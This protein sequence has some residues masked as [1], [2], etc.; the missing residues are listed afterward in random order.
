MS[1]L[2]TKA[3]ITS[4]ILG[5][6][7]VLAVT[8]LIGSQFGSPVLPFMAMFSGYILTGIIAGWLSK[9]ETILEPGLASALVAIV[10]YIVV[11]SWDLNCF[12]L[13]PSQAFHTNM[14]LVALNGII[15]TFVGAWAGEKFQGTL[16]NSGGTQN[17]GIEWAWVLC[18]T[19]FGVAV[20]L[21][22]STA[23][24]IFFGAYVEYLTVAFVI[25]IFFTGFT[26]GFRS[27]GVTMKEAAFAGFFALVAAFDIFKITLDQ[28]STLLTPGLLIAGFLL[29]LLVAFGG[30]FAGEKFQAQK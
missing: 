25:G 10:S 23:I 20:S 14:I 13:L 5:I 3:L 15:L 26:V 19:V 11:A 17:T 8:F 9:G 18:G 12:K 16:D 6:I 1:T 2:D 21:L 7:I 29:S 28:D 27:P 4:A 24:V 30:G 22:L